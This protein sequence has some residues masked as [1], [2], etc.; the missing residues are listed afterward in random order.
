[1]ITPTSQFPYNLLLLLNA[2]GTSVVSVF[3]GFTTPNKCHVLNSKQFFVC[4]IKCDSHL[5]SLRPSRNPS[6]KMK[7]ATVRIEQSHRNQNLFI[8][9]L[10]LMEGTF[11]EGINQMH[12]IFT[13]DGTGMYHLRT[14]RMKWSIRGTIGINWGSLIFSFFSTVSEELRF[15]LL[16]SKAGW[17]I[18]SD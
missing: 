10:W 8:H 9:K 18:N 13:K 7:D 6:I 14:I 5:L 16:V 15:I 3:S 2:E 1:M 4:A 11:C 17:I 12:F